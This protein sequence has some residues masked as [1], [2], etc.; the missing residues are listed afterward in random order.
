VRIH[1]PQGKDF[2][3]EKSTIFQVK[4]KNSRLRDARRAAWLIAWLMASSAAALGQNPTMGSVTAVDSSASTSGF[5]AGV[6]LDSTGEG[7]LPDAPMPKVVPKEKAEAASTL[8]PRDGPDYEQT[9]SVGASQGEAAAQD[10]QDQVA[11]VDVDNLLPGPDASFSSTMERIA[12]GREGSGMEN[13]ESGGTLGA[14]IGPPAR[15][16]VPLNQCP[17]DHTHARECRVHVKDLVIESSIFL[18]FQNAGNLY[19]GYW[20]RYETTTGAWWN[21]YVNS[22][23]DWRWKNWSDNNPFLDDYVGHPIMG[24]ITDS[25]WIQNDPKG[26]TLEQSN[27]WPYYRSRLRALAFSTFYSFEWKLGPIGEASV[28]HNGDHFYH[29]Q[30]TYTTEPEIKVVALM[31]DTGLADRPMLPLKAIESR[32]CQRP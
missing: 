25:L 21:R 31:T 14:G 5:V 10:S 24:A 8:L 32:K 7:D 11:A 6:R 15:P 27:T 9:V 1:L 12:G 4:P 13:T 20:Y 29:D 26:M 17:F 16:Y 23:E 28:G 19:T 18:A 22:V 3:D 30:G 2:S